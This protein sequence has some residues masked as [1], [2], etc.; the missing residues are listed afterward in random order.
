MLLLQQMSVLFIFMILGFICGKMKVLS[1]EATKAISWIVV[2][3]ANPALI[4]SASV[5]GNA[6]IKGL[7]LLT[8][9]GI[10]ILVFVFMMVISVFLP[11]ILRVSAE[12]KGVF[13]VMT[14]FSNIG[15]M[16]FPVISAVYGTNALLYAS[17]FLFPYNILIY[18]YGIMAMGKGDGSKQKLQLKKI[19]NI[20][21]I[22]CMVSITIYLIDI[23]MPTVVTT[24][25][26]SLSNLT[27]PLSMFVIGQ[28]M[29]HIKA[30]AL[31]KDVRLFVFS[32]IKLILLPITGI[33][34]LRI[35]VQDSLIIG[36]CMI[37]M[38]TP[39][40]SMTAML[41]QQYDGN[42]VLAS[43]GVALTTIL[44]VAT[45]PLVSWILSL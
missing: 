4:L 30:G 44:S 24:T 20:G 1:D 32:I 26:T 31:F 29:I 25:V 13:R 3:I 2:N 16:G 38:A 33:L 19:L 12:D 36:V 39:V 14:I 22:A 9:F 28:S 37:M 40:G 34:L 21:V 17:L 5:S 27:A 6:A 41:A 42:Y 11:Y 10:A 7:E 23:P 18:T 45:I 15:F 35:F 43:K 8:T